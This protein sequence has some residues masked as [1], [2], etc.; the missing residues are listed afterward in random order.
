MVNGILNMNLGTHTMRSLH[1]VCRA[2][3]FGTH[4]GIGT[5]TMRSLHGVGH[6][7]VLGTHCMRSEN[8]IIP[9]LIYEHSV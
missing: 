8:D 3:V 7:V 5:H 2:V 4:T 1:V 9:L 6:A